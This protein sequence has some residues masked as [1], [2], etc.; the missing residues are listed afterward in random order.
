VVG[1][2]AKVTAGRTAA[3]ARGAGGWGHAMK[4]LQDG[5]DDTDFE[6]EGFEDILV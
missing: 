1:A 5:A 4:Q 6:E 2:S 3:A